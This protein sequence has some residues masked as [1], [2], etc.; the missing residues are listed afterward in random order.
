MKKYGQKYIAWILI[1]IFGVAC[2][3]S[4]G[5]RVFCVGDEGHSNIEQAVE[6]CCDPDTS[7]QSRGPLSGNAR[8]D[9]DCGDCSDI[10]ISALLSTIL[11]GKSSRE[12]PPLYLTP[13]CYVASELVTFA[14][15]S[16]KND[17]S[18]SSNLTLSQF[19]ITKTVLIC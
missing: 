11:K 8:E 17:N 5:S 15:S 1:S 10:D 2:S 4:S 19:I 13:A 6:S 9:S 7:P 3:L 18:K 16:V 14:T 12:F